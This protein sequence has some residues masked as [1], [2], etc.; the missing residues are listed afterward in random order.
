MRFLR[1]DPYEFA[2]DFDAC[3]VQQTEDEDYP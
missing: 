3:L 2:G 1:N